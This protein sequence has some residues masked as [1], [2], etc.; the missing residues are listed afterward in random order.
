MFCPECGGVGYSRL[1]GGKCSWRCNKCGIDI[2][3]W[4]PFTGEYIESSN[5]IWNPFN[6]IVLRVR[7]IVKK[8]YK[9]KE[10]EKC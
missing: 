3:C 5:T 7:Y 10:G 9:K 4:C 1:Y 2:R 6:A 8:M